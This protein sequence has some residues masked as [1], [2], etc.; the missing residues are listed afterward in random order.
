VQSIGVCYGVIGNNL[1]SRSE[2][3][4]LYR[5]KGITDMRI[6]FADGQALSALRNSGI[7]LIIDVGNDQLRFGVEFQGREW[8]TGAKNEDDEARFA[9]LREDAGWIVEPVWSADVYGH[10]ARVEDVILEG[11]RRARRR[12]T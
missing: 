11:V 8:H 6:Y 4:Q 12:A 3:V 1:P 2:V 5:S 10:H 7:G 9:W